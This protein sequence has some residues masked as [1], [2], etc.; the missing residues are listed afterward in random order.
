MKKLSALTGLVCAMM[1]LLSMTSCGDSEDWRDPVNRFN[2]TNAMN[3][4]LDR[5]GEFGTN[6][7]ATRQWFYDNYDNYGGY[8]D[9]YYDADYRT[10]VSE[11]S[12]WYAKCQVTMASI[13]ATGA[14]NGNLM[15]NW[16]NAG[17]S[18]YSLATC[19]AEYDFDLSS[20]GAK[21]G[22]GQEHRW[23]YSDG[24]AESRTGFNWSV[25][26]FGNIIIDF[27]SAEGQGR[28]VEMVVYYSDL[29][30]LSDSQGIFA[31]KM[32]SN[33]QGL[34][35]YDNFS[36]RRVTY[37]KPA[38]GTRTTTAGRDFAGKADGMRRIDSE[39][40]QVTLTGSRR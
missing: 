40:K 14:W 24:S 30:K 9:L 6:D 10:F 32:T 36:F 37:A 19:S 7:E 12:S 23:N 17:S 29:D 11:L 35:E 25:D 20:T 2:L 16:R 1:L 21:G 15:M 8:Y 13:L 22:R 33:T 28:G 39:K 26:G 31:G 18:T 27:D 3:A 38:L 4:Y 34:D 5:Y